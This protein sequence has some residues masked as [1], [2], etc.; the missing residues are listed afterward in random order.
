[1]RYWQ[2]HIQASFLYDRDRLKQTDIEAF[3]DYI[4]LFIQQPLRENN[5]HEGYR[6]TSYVS[7][8]K[9]HAVNL[10]IIRQKA[11]SG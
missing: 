9:C 5:C 6:N 7:T 2:L 3:I 4:C 10:L 8:I 11:D 1:M